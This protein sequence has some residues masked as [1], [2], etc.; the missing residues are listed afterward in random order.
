[1]DKLVEAML[2]PRLYV[3][4]SSYATMLH[5]NIQSGV[6]KFESYDIPKNSLIY[7]VTYGLPKNLLT[8]IEEDSLQVVML[9]A[10]AIVKSYTTSKDELKKYIS[11]EDVDRLIENICWVSNSL[12]KYD[13]ELIY[14]MRENLKVVEKSLRVVSNNPTLFNRDIKKAVEEYQ[15]LGGE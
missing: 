8:P 5:R 7:Q 14:E 1:M 6:E 10:Y 2:N 11:K 15:K 12:E 9:E 4:V 13:T 3:R